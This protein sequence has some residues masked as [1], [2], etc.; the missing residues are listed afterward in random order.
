[1]VILLIVV[2]STAHLA[3]LIAR[4]AWKP[5]RFLIPVQGPAGSLWLLS[6]K[7]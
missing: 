5:P 2:V 1:M 4:E 7:F 6:L 3:M